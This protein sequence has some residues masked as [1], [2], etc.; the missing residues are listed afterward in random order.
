MVAVLDFQKNPL[1]KELLERWRSEF[2]ACPKNVLA[3]NACSKLDVLD[4]CTSRQRLQ[5]ISHQFTHKV[6]IDAKPL[7]NQKNSGRCWLFAALN[8]IRLPFMKHYQ[9][10]EFQ[11]S[12]SHLFFWD[13]IERANFYLNSVVETYQRGEAVDG[14]LVSHLLKSPI[15]DGGQWDMVVNLILIHGLMPKSAFPESFS[16]ESSLRMNAIL[17]SKLREY[18]RDLRALMKSEESVANL[19][20]TIEKQMSCIY[21]I[22]SICLGIP[23]TTFSWEY[24]NKNKEYH[25]VENV[26]PLQFYNEYVKPY[27]NLE[28]KVCLVTDPR[29]TNEYN[30]AYSVD[31]LGN[32]VGGRPIIYNN[33]PVELLMKLSADSIKDNEAVWFGCEVSKRFDSKL[34]LNDLTIHDYKAVFD[35][36]IQL[37]MTKAERLKYG[38]SAM[39]HAMVISAVSIDQET[40][41]TTKWRVE[42]S[43]GED[44]NHKGYILMT[45]EWFKE[46]VFEIVVD[47]KYVPESVLDVFNQ[48]PTVLPAWDPMGMLATGLCPCQK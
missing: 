46:F 27:Y 32:V 37:P 17:K 14:R 34:G 9:L 15:E 40:N 21:R 31:C 47:K 13:K 5:E 35:T 30:K 24:R 4:V 7:T 23:P 6:D 48:T 44:R 11:F 1:N 42:N 3:Q 45:S 26:T 18:T 38:E 41:E 19:A 20:A 39:S 8:V 2:Y 29:P 10:D 22:V 25:S 43:W 16:S 33:Q 28:N 36:D 12:Q